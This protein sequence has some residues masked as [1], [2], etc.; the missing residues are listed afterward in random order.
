MG[1]AIGMEVQKEKTN[2]HQYNGIGK[3]G[4]RWPMIFSAEALTYYT[5]VIFIFLISIRVLQ[6]H[7]RKCHDLYFN[8][9]KPMAEPVEITF[10]KWG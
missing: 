10:G 9:S 4:V 2:Q 8:T 7:R 6:A 3:D 5:N 1:D